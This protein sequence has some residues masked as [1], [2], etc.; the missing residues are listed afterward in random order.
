MKFELVQSTN[1]ESGHRITCE[2]LPKTDKVLCIM[3]K[4]RLELNRDDTV[5]AR[6]V[7]YKHMTV[8]KSELHGLMEMLAMRGWPEVDIDLIDGLTKV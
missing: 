2:T 4:I 3:Y 1:D 8:K 6:L 5:Y 7:L